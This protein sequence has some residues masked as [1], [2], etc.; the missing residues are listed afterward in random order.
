MGAEMWEVVCVVV[1][2][3]AVVGWCFRVL[4]VTV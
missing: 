4:L 1:C 3:A 2:A